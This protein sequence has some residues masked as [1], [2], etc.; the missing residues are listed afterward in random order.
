VATPQGTVRY[1]GVKYRS[2]L[3]AK[4]AAFF[5]H[6]GW[7]AVYDPHTDG[8]VSF[9]VRELDA[10]FIRVDP[11]IVE[12]TQSEIGTITVGLAPADWPGLTREQVREAWDKA[13]NDV[14]AV[15]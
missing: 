4:W 2:R 6:V 10:W 11:R 14:L 7:D 12:A 13:T 5:H 15:A 1:R 8:E 9:L 3:E